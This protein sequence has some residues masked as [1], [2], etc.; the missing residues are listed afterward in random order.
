M[1]KLIEWTE[2]NPSR[3]RKVVLF[4]TVFVFLFV[5]VGIFGVAAFGIAMS[6]VIETFYITFVGLMVAIYGFYTGTSSDKSTALADKAAD[7]MMKKLEEVEKSK[8]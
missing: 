8:K 4:S 1:K 3:G 5:T 7:L 6:A 2:A